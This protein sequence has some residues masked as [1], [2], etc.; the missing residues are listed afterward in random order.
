MIRPEKNRRRCFIGLRPR[1]R[2]ERRAPMGSR[3][4][5]DGDSRNIPNDFPSNYEGNR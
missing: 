3:R 4:D 1:F 5:L 2:S